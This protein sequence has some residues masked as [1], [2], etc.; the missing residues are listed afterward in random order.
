MED[1]GVETRC[2][3][4]RAELK[5]SYPLFSLDEFGGRR[6]SVRDTFAPSLCGSLWISLALR[7]ALGAFCLGGMIY[8][9]A[10]AFDPLSSKICWLYFLTHWTLVVTVLYFVL[11][12]IL[13]LTETC[14]TGFTFLYQPPNP[15]PSFLVKFAWAVYAIAMPANLGVVLMYW[16]LDFD[17]K[18]SV[19]DFHNVFRHGITCLLLGVDANVLALVPLR[20]K[21]VVFPLAFAVAYLLWTV[22]NS[23]L[24][25]GNGV[26]PLEDA[27]QANEDDALYSVLDWKHNPAS[28]AVYALV[29][30]FAVFPLLFLLSWTFS[31]VSAGCRCNGSR[32]RLYSDSDTSVPEG[33]VGLIGDGLS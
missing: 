29:I 26:W 17:P 11:V 12:V 33:E 23:I 19:V 18:T 22:V 30:V 5:S 7:L 20:A 32:R 6:L 25:L 9:I 14:T 2:G 15:Q 16:T 8:S 21:Q 31:A 24:G 3:Q 27:D 13:H 4:L 10:V 1:S 28:A